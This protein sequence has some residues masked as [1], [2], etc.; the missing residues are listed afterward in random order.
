MARN[1][2]AIGRAKSAYGVRSEMSRELGSLTPRIA[3]IK[4]RMEEDEERR[5]GRNLL[6][7]EL[8]KMATGLEKNRERTRQFRTGA[9]KAGVDPGEMSFLDKIGLT[10]PST[11]ERFMTERGMATG[12][13]LL[14]IGRGFQ[15]G[16][17][18]G[19]RLLELLGPRNPLSSKY[20]T[21]KPEIGIKTPFQI[22]NEEY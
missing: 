7:G 10:G 22:R 19:M 15:T 6:L 17:P 16:D 13:Q 8:S 2:S 18:M 4:R 14:N 21:L 5:K 20:E 3:G 1:T 11:E 12:E 9:E